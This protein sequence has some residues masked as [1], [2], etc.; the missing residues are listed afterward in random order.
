MIISGHLDQM[1]PG[2]PKTARDPSIWDYRRTPH[3]TRQLWLK[4]A[5]QISNGGQEPGRWR[6]A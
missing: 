3:P 5:A 1:F 4:S 6:S 2:L